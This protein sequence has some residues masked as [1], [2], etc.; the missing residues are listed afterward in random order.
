MYMTDVLEKATMQ[1]L[2]DDL[3]K[4]MA[5]LGEFIWQKS[6]VDSRS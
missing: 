3:I 1:A 5:R 6:M 2:P 4:E